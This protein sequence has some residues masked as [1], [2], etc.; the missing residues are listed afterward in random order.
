MWYICF[1]CIPN[2]IGY[3]NGVQYQA[4]KQQV[5]QNDHYDCVGRNLNDDSTISSAITHVRA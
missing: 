5:D 1:F 3:G 2:Q 4:Q